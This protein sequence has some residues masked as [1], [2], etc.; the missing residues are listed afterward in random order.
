MTVDVK[1]H[2]FARIWLSA[3]G[4]TYQMDIDRLA[5]LI[6]EVCEEFVMELENGPQHD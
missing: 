1:C 5:V 3:G 6:Q 2:D 4:W